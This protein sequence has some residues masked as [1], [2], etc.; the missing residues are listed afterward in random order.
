MST[1][2]TKV[3]SLSEALPEKVH[4]LQSDSFIMALCAAANA[5]TTATTKLADLTEISYTNCSSRA[6]TVS[7]SAQ[8]SGTYKW[9]LTDLVITASGGNV[10]AFRYGVIYNN[11][12]TNKEVIGFYDYGVDFTLTNGNSFTFDFDGTNGVLQ[13]A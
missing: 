6:I 1:A 5:P 4:N 3:Y 2:F 11:T 7:S 12:A 10:A 13:L 8:S 9:I